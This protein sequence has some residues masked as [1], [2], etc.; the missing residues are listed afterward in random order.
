MRRDAGE[1]HGHG[2]D[3]DDWFHCLYVWRT[4]WY[5]WELW[6][7][8]RLLFWS[9]FRRTRRL[10]EQNTDRLRSC[11]WQTRTRVKIWLSIFVHIMISAIQKIFQDLFWRGAETWGFHES[12][13]YPH[14]YCFLVWMERKN[15]ILYRKDSTLEHNCNR[16]FS[17]FRR[18]F[19]WMEC[20][21]YQFLRYYNVTKG[22]RVSFNE[23]VISGFA[24]IHVV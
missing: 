5:V 11:R 17:Q 4:R 23:K 22:R 19:S 15:G 2:G 24:V 3:A 20:R 16:W 1:G 7:L 8:I 6:G 10:N 18:C 14:M 13:S 21:Q 9:H 12:P